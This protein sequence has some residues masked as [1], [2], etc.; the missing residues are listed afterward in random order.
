MSEKSKASNT[1]ER[2]CIS[3]TTRG[4]LV[5][6]M[7][8]SLAGISTDLNTTFMAV[9]IFDEYLDKVPERISVD[10]LRSLC[11]V[12]VWIAS[13]FNDVESIRLSDVH[14]VLVN[15]RISEDELRMQEKVVLQTINFKIRRET[16]ISVLKALFSDFRNEKLVCKT[17]KFLALTTLYDMNFCKIDPY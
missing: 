5:D 4:I 6:S 3:D 17:A 1:L 11:A 7:I 15:S 14:S 8:D 13:K 12:C 16:P 2:H 9:Y 10:E